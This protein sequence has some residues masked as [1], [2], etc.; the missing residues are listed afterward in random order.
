MKC[1]F[2]HLMPYLHL[3]PGVRAQYDSCW[4][5][6]PNGAYDPRK[7]HEL[8]NRYLDELELAEAVGFDGLVLNEHHATAYGMMPAPNLICAALARRT[9]RA[10]IAILGN[11]TPL[12]EHPLMIAEELAM[13]DNIMG[14]RLICGFV[15]G[16]GVEYLVW[17]VNPT[18]SHERFHESQEL[19]VRAWTAT[20]PF[21]FEGAH[22]HVPWVNVWPRPY[23]QPHPPIWIPTN[24]STE[25][26]E[27]AARADHRY[28]YLQNLSAAAACQKYM[29]LYHEVAARA[30]WEATPANLGWGSPTYV[31]ETDD[32]A[33]REMKPHIE[34]FFN[35]FF[36]NP[37]HRFLPPGYTSLESMRRIAIDKIP[38]FGPQTLD[39]LI[40]HGVVLCGSAGTVREQL[41]HN[42]RSW[43]FDT[44]VGV[45]HF[46]TLPRELTEKNLRLYAS[47]VIPYVRGIHEPAAAATEASQ[48]GST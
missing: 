24:G 12:R 17:G 23:Q 5:V 2:F 26:V 15:R 25:T 6:L 3:D 16:I 35:M 28:K 39:N 47:E 42:A 43:G 34:S 13:L 7:G 48:G 37:P 40:K 36:R 22:Y 32:I 8:Y 10:S 14:G 46:G 31:A 11:I 30:G 33:Y 18:L 4:M 21:A 20:E 44:H 41:A 9:T 45:L 1:F 29:T 27:W 38:I 19:I